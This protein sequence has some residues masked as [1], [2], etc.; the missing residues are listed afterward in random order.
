MRVFD[1][2]RS[3]VIPDGPLNVVRWEQYGLDGRLPFGAMWY[4]VAPRSASPTDQHFE[5]ELSIVLSGQASVEA[6]GTIT[7]VE[8]GNAFLLDGDEPH[9]IH[10][11]GDDPVLIFSTYWD[12]AAVPA[13][14]PPAA[15]PGPDA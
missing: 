4:T 12:P 15:T 8:P 5:S 2:D 9:V 14:G 6:G 7:D 13:P 10:N 11:R 3:A 1:R